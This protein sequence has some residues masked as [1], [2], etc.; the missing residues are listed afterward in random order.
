[1]KLINYLKDTRSE[2]RHVSWPTRKQTIQFTMLVVVISI[3]TTILLGSA[4]SLFAYLLE[5]FII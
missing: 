1:M 5:E 2:M 3:V 4:D